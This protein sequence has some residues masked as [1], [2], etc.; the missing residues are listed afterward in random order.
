MFWAIFGIFINHPIKFVWP[1]SYENTF[2]TNFCHTFKRMKFDRFSI[3]NHP[4]LSIHKTDVVSV[5]M[6]NPHKFNFFFLFFAYK[7]WCFSFLFSFSFNFFIFFHKSIVYDQANVL[8]ITESNYENT[9]VN[10]KSQWWPIDDVVCLIFSFY[11]VFFGFVV[12][13]V[14]VTLEVSSTY[15]RQNKLVVLF[16]FFFSLFSDQ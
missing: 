7:I 8:W 10:R 1:F 11:F 15:T 12:S 13:C 6:S 2:M 14:C 3:M 16:Y 9:L 5:M 4:F